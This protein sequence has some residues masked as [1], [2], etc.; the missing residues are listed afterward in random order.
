MTEE[1]D[2]M[3][4]T[5][6]HDI[7]C[8]YCKHEILDSWEYGTDEIEGDLGVIECE[9]CEKKFTARRDTS[10]TYDSF[11]APCLNGEAEH[12]YRQIVGIPK[13]HFKGKFR[14]YICGDEIKKDD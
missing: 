4:Y 12:D 3:D 13:E 9:K 5:L 7:T 14:C 8:P 11:P 2:E 1:I 6:C 10:I